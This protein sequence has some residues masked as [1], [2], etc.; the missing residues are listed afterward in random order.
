MIGIL[1]LTHAG[2]GQ[3]FI[4]TAR[5]IGLNSEDSLLALSIDPGQPPELLR[6]QV[7]KSIKSVSRGNGVL[8]LTD[9][10]GGTPTNLSLSFLEDG[11]VEVVT[12]LNLPMIIKA[13]NSRKDSDLR[14]L[15]KLAAEAGKE[16]IYLAGEFLRQRL[17][18]RNAGEK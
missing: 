5:L 15:A 16:N 11:K 2:L 9:L 17:S 7:A 6:E 3:Q 18:R 12:G 13:V 8:I 4:D 14:T 10:F 1:L